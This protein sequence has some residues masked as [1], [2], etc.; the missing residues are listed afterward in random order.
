MN[1][2]ANDAKGPMKNAASLQELMPDLLL[3]LEE[4]QKLQADTGLKDLFEDASELLGDAEDFVLKVV[5]HLSK[6]S[7]VP[8]KTALSI[9]N[10]DIEN[11]YAAAAKLYENGSYSSAYNLFRLLVMIDHFDYRFVFGMAACMQTQ[12]DFFQAATTYLFSTSLEPDYAWS[13][14]HAAECYLK[15]NEP[16]SALICLELCVKACKD[17]KFKLL[18]QR[19]QASAEKLRQKLEKT[20]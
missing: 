17:E 9:E 8:A 15:I 6:D 18:A 19:A 1:E 10:N 13:F 2:N 20:S 5:R 3:N 14:F 7:G 16:G 11:I 4:G 12:G